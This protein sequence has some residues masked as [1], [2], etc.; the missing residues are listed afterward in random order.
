M[1]SQAEDA[2]LVECLRSKQ[3][4]SQFDQQDTHKTFKII[5]R[6]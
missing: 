4:K 3:K 2:K 6:L 5:A 1:C